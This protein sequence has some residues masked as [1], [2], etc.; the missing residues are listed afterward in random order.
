M[1]FAI[2]E[3]FVGGRRRGTY[4]KNTFGIALSLGNVTKLSLLFIVWASCCKLIL[5]L[6]MKFYNVDCTKNFL[7]EQFRE[8]SNCS[9][10]PKD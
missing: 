3:L 7:M 10:I 2:L 1:N 5:L 4:V 9:G 6:N 8:A